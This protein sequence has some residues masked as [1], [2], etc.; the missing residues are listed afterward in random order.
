M[1]DDDLMMLLAQWDDVSAAIDR[2]VTALPG[3]MTDA[4]ANLEVQ[5]SKMRR[6]INE[7]TRSTSAGR[8]ALKNQ[9]SDRG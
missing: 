7:V 1:T 2:V 4:A 9:E 5:R 6:T 3:Q 8:L